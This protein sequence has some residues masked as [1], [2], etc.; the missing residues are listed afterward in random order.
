[1]NL[2]IRLLAYLLAVR[3]RPRLAL[4]QDAP[5]LTFRVWPTDL[6]TSLHMNN[7]RYLA[8]M[9]LGRLDVMVGA[10]LWRPLLA[11]GWTPIASAIMIRYRRELRLFDQ[12][13]LESRILA[14]DQTTVVME[15]RFILASGPRQGELAARALFKGGLYDRKGRRFVPVSE[16]MSEIGVSAES[17]APSVEIE[18]FLA[19]DRSMR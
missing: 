3:W 11:N 13:R 9:D 1:M 10:G 4:P 2:W 15:Q 12:I 17:P 8:L 16:L 19:A 14:W 18:A 6:D 5:R 7:S